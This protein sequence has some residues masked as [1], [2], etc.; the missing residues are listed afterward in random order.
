MERIGNYLFIYGVTYIELGFG[1][2]SLAW[3]PVRLD[4][5][6]G[7]RVF[8]DHRSP[9]DGVWVFERRYTMWCCDR[10]TTPWC[11]AIADLRPILHRRGTIECVLV[12]GHRVRCTSLGM[13]DQFRMHCVSVGCWFVNRDDAVPLR[14][15]IYCEIG[16][17]IEY[18]L[19]G[20]W[21][22]SLTC[23]NQI[24]FT[25]QLLPFDA[26][27]AFHFAVIGWFHVILVNAAITFF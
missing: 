7:R 8:C 15:W 13:A 1:I 9:S 10:S 17:N 22:L 27:K 18:W 14:N 12:D 5:M 21:T 25:V 11:A 16:V 24:D 4:A 20:D 2:Y 19:A 26:Q 3:H 6:F 23:H